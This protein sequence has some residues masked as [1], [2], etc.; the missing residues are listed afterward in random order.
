MRL[1]FYA[2]SILTMLM[3]ALACSPARPPLT[4]ADVLA[5]KTVRAQRRLI[6]RLAHTPNNE[7]DLHAFL[8]TVSG[9]DGRLRLRWLRDLSYGAILPFTNVTA[10]IVRSAVT[11][12][13]TS[14]A[15]R[16][17]LWYW[18]PDHPNDE[19]TKALLVKDTYVCA[20]KMAFHA[21]R[22]APE[23]LDQRVSDVLATLQQ[24]PRAHTTSPEAWSA[25]YLASRGKHVPDAVVTRLRERYSRDW[26]YD[27][28]LDLLPDRQGTHEEMQVEPGTRQKPE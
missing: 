28:L 17:E 27:R 6:Q 13:E 25:F 20:L 18:R 11:E 2:C 26:R 4:T 21:G 15:N 1:A 12:F 23:Y 22:D 19:A 5:A 7:D 8:T 14:Y 9:L 16:P 10:R 24:D 3:C